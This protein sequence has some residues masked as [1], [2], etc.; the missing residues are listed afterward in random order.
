MTKQA[1]MVRLA[2]LFFALLN[3]LLVICGYGV[4]PV[5][6]EELEQAIT[7]LVTALA[8]LWNIIGALRK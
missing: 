1:M 5:N 8:T 2:V 4:L 7:T 6:T 3:Q